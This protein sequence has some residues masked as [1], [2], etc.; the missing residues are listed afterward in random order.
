MCKERGQ[1][2]RTVLNVYNLLLIFFRYSRLL[3]FFTYYFKSQ[4][5]KHVH[6]IFRPDGPGQQVPTPAQDHFL[7][8][9]KPRQ[10]EFGISRW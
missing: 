5:T 3:S 1:E 4:T 7:A 6:E 10:R 2:F 8:P 9:D